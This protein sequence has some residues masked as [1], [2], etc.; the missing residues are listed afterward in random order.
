MGSAGGGVELTKVVLG[1]FVGV[2]F[3]V[4]VQLSGKHTYTK[5]HARCQQRKDSHY[6]APTGAPTPG[7]SN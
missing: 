4:Y 7:V 5:K 3:L 6:A 1:G 2:E